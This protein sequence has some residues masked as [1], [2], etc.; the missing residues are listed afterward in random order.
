MRR[1]L[2]TGARHV[3]HVFSWTAQSA[4]VATCMHSMRTQF[5][6]ASKHTEHLFS[7]DELPPREL[8]GEAPLRAREPGRRVLELGRRRRRAR[9]RDLRL[10]PL[11]GRRERLG[12]RAARVRP[13]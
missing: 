13:S 4:H 3:G 9:A 10:E 12:Q 8:D 2:E 11:E 7:D 5:F 6:A 1:T